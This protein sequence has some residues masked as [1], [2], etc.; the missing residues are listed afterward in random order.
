[1]ASPT[2]NR[3]SIDQP[4][5]TWQKQA[6]QLPFW[7]RRCSAWAVEMSLVIVGGLAPFTIGAISN[8][9][10]VSVPLNPVVR[11]TAETVAATLGL[12]MRDRQP[13]VSPLTNLFWSGALVLPIAIASWQLYLLSTTGQTLP[14]RWFGVRVVNSRQ[15]PPGFSRIIARETIGRWGIPVGI[16]YIVWQA[17]GAFPNLLVMMGLSGIMIAA[18]GLMGRRFHSRTGHDLLAGTYVQ[19]VATSFFTNP[20]T[21]YDWEEE[22][23]SVK[24][25]VL[26]SKPKLPE[27]NLWQWMRQY[28][29][30]TLIIVGS[31]SMAAVLGTFIGTQVYIQNQ[32]NLRA[33]QNQDNEVFLALVGRLSPAANTDPAQRR[34]AILALGTL[35]DPRAVPLL[36]D[37]LGQEDD[38][39]LLEV[40]QQALVSTGPVALPNIRK[41]NQALRNDLDSMRFGA[42]Q[43]QKRIVSQRQQATQRA[44]A[45]ILKV[46]GGFIQQ[47]DLSRV[48]LG[49][50]TTPPAQFTLVL[51]QTDLSGISFR[52]AIMTHANF[53]NSRFAS[54]GPD[55]RFNTFDDLISDLS[56]ADLTSVDL[57]GAFMSPV[58]MRRT[59]LL[60]GTLDRANLSNADLNGS[61]F[62]SASL[63]GTNLENAN[64]KEASL[65]GADI[66]NAN[67]SR[68]DLKLARMSQ[69]NAQGTQFMF[70]DL[71]EA[72]LQRGSLSGADFQGANL[73]NANLSQAQLTGTNF[74]NA[75][76][77]NA[78]LSNADLSLVNLQGARLHG[79]NFEGVTFVVNRETRTDEFIEETAQGATSNRMQGADFS[80]V[81][82]LSDAQITYICNQ[83]GIHPNCE[84]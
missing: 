81:Q 3:P 72:D 59:N 26:I 73:Q 18:D 19:P 76:L 52:S 57:T 68:S 63:I 48:H 60:N 69:I 24:A 8:R 50:T 45:K 21:S 44:I 17:T 27:W 78:N 4:T 51:D 79:A 9:G 46:Y 39:I 58:I 53:R 25:I 36:V 82:N 71:R 83:G 61:N 6:K 62:S 37:L 56:G 80:R 55:G 12:P 2:A 47:A 16:A 75:R 34:G 30:L 64:L 1:M 40:I 41:L 31:A 70:A 29:G 32:A 43:R 5:P 65:T 66:T 15:L 49:Q 42:D 35:Q 77:Q 28:P 20:F 67:L 54:P 33:S 22:N 10:P 13:S 74:R 84:S 23:Q 38:P 7:V 14:K 11:G